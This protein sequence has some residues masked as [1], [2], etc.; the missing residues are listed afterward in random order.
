MLQ[1]NSIL[2]ICNYLRVNGKSISLKKLEALY[3]NYL[4]LYLRENNREVNISEEHGYGNCYSYALDLSYPHIFHNLFKRFYGDGYGFLFNI[5]FT[6]GNRKIDFSTLGLYETFLRD[7]NNLGIEVFPSGLNIN[8]EN[9][10]YKIALF[11]SRE[12]WPK[13]FHFIR[14]NSDGTWSHKLGYDFYPR[15]MGGPLK[16][17]YKYELI[18]IVEIVKPRERKRIMT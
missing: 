16:F 3:L 18:K 6:T 11:G 13:D 17:D 12:G 8:S 14:E 9:G 1:Y 10:G 15:H 4:K 7:C 2:E 5:G